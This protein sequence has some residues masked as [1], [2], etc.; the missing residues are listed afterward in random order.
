MREIVIGLAALTG[1]GTAGYMTGSFGSGEYYE[2]SPAQVSSDLAGMQIPAEFSEKSAGVRIE[3]ISADNEQVHWELSMDGGP[4]ADVYAHLDP[5]GSGTRVSIDFAM[6]DGEGT[7]RL[8]RMLPMGSE[9]FAD[10]AELA[11]TEQIDATLDRRPFD[12][13]KFAGALV[14]YAAANPGKIVKFQQNVQD[15]ALSNMQEFEGSSDADSGF[16]ESADYAASSESTDSGGDGGD[17]W[18]N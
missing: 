13:D 18:G 14:G 6:R 12:K 9:F 15:Q 16:D 8:D 2:I 4:V 7:E 17:D 11:L 1:L 3:A 5:S 10:M